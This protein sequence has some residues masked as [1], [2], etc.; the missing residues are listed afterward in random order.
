LPISEA[1]GYLE[2]SREANSG[3]A[4]K[5]GLPYVSWVGAPPHLLGSQDTL[6]KVDRRRL[7]PTA[8]TIAEM[9]KSFMMMP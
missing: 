8:E 3:Y 7:R 2:W 9:I 4:R 1:A 5:G 6:E